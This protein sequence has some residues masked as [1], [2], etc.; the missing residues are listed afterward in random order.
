MN[1]NMVGL[2][3]CQMNPDMSFY[4]YCHYTYERLWQA[5]EVMC[6]KLLRVA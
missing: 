3:N 4:I 6:V 1:D 5:I 2:L